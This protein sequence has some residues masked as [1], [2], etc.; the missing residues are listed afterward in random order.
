MFDQTDHNF[1]FSFFENLEERVLFDGVPD[2]ALITP[3]LAQPQ[4]IP[5]QS[6]N[7]EQTQPSAQSQV[8]LIVIDAGIEDGQILLNSLVASKP[9]TAFEVYFIDSTEDGIKQITDR[10]SASDTDFNAIH[11]LTHGNAGNIELGSSTLNL[12]NVSR[13]QDD[14]A[15]WSDSLTSDADILFYGCEVAGN[16]NGQELLEIVSLT[17]GADVA[18]STDLTGA[19][20]QNANWQLEF[21]SGQVETFALSAEN[22]TGTLAVEATDGSVSVEDAEF[23]GA[24]TVSLTNNGLCRKSSPCSTRQRVLV[25]C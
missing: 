14:L 19:S 24:G 22:W 25:K 10:L 2:G 13:Y 23:S 18:A 4:A 7:L 11:V 3:E 16:E 6:I 9:G 8:E 21:V 20:N 15:S 5:A 17:T 12:G 1:R